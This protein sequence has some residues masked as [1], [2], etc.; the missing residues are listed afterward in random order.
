MLTAA[1]MARAKAEA[2]ALVAQQEAA[3]AARV[4]AETE[5][6]HIRAVELAL[7]EGES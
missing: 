4:H 5:R 7:L 2:A 6:Q 1:E 3:E